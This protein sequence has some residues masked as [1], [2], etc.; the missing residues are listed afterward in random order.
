MDL[1]T[2][3]SPL[4]HPLSLRFPKLLLGISVSSSPNFPSFWPFFIFPPTKQKKKRK[5][6]S[7][8]ST[9]RNYTFVFLFFGICIFLSTWKSQP[10]RM[11]LQAACCSWHK[12]TSA[13]YISTRRS[14][15]FDRLPG[16]EK[17][18]KQKDYENIMLVVII[19]YD[20]LLNRNIKNGFLYF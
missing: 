2:K 5:F 9:K 11:S 13:K 20:E 3:S 1:C 4:L 18:N 8:W 10:S 7:L 17:Q 15:N 16:C 19:V 6:F 12:R 14:R